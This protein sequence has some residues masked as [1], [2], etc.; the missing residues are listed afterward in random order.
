MLSFKRLL[1]KF[2]EVWSRFSIYEHIVVLCGTGIWLYG[3]GTVF[4]MNTKYNRY[5]TVFS[6]QGVGVGCK[7]GGGFH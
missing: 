2:V 7:F 1:N 5:R 6:I 3:T 4:Y